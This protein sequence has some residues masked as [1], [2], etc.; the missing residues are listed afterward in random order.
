MSFC[1]SDQFIAHRG[2]QH[3]YPEN[4]LSGINAAIAA[5]AVNVEVDVQFSRDGLAMLYHDHDLHRISGLPGLLNDFDGAALE[6]MPANEPLRWTQKFSNIRIQ[7]LADL[8]PIIQKYPTVHF[9][10]E[11]KQESLVNHSLEYCLQHLYDLFQPVMRQ[12]TFISFDPLAVKHAK[13]DF[14]FP[15]VGLVLDDWQQRYQAI[16]DTQSDIAYINLKRIP[17]DAVIEAQCPIAVY[18][19]ADATLALE[20]LKRGAAKIESFAI[21]KLLQSLCLTIA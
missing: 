13:Q 18:E 10:I 16:S 20:T 5:G 17:R 3:K 21:D 2:L 19:I 7:A 15:R 6:K 12:I 4:S 1:R 11:F 8:L 9:Y 14:N